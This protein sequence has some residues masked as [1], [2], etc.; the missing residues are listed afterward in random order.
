MATFVGGQLA[1]AHES[2]G[3]ALAGPPVHPAAVASV[4]SDTSTA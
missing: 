2:I 4:E 3:S 1:W